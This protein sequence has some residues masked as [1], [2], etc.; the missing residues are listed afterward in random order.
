[1]KQIFLRDCTVFF[2]ENSADPI[3]SFIR[4]QATRTT[5]D[6]TTEHQDLDRDKGDD[7]SSL[8]VEPA[9]ILKSI[10]TLLPKELQKQD[11]ADGQNMDESISQLQIGSGDDLTRIVFSSSES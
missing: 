10:I 3:M 4:S 6:M 5:D 11:D 9:H 7:S 2:T 1:M 8:F